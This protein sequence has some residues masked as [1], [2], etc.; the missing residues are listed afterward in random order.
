MSLSRRVK[1]FFFRI[2]GGTVIIGAIVFI[3]LN[4]PSK[5]HQAPVEFG[6]NFSPP[7]AESFGLDWK[8]TYI[9]ILDDLGVKRF[10]LAAYW[11]VVEPQNDSFNYD[12]LDFQLGEAAKR[13]AKVIL[14][15]G[16]KLP[17]W[18]ECHT[19]TWVD[20]SKKADMERELLEYEQNVVVR[21]KDHPVIERWQIENEL[22]FPFGVCPHWLGLGTLKKEIMQVRALDSKPIVVTDSGEWTFWIPISFY[23]DVLGISMYRE[24]WNDTFGYIPFPISP[25][26]YQARAKLISPWKKN[27]IV[28]ELQTE[29]WNKKAIQELTNE[30]IHTSMSVEKMKKNIEFAKNVGFSEVYLWGAEVWYW[31]KEHG[32]PSYWDAAKKEFTHSFD[33]GVE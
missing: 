2:I 29:P 25:G 3:F 14:A 15:I 11:D 22:L 9:A 19:P 16:R 1:N 28:T 20:P 30:E 7:Y 13:G 24:S 4:I 6:V 8:K 18:P 5:E 33:K 10:R 31:L 26:Y 21:Y 17:R 12:A 23:G 27:V 32:D